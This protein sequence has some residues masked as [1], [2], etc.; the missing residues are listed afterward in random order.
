[1][2]ERSG[3]AILLGTALS[4]GA[5]LMLEVVL[6][7]IFAVAQFHHFAFVAV[8]LALLGF[9]AAGSFLYVWPRLG[10]GGPGR[11]ATLAALQTAAIIG[12]YMAANRVPFDSFTV[13]WDRR[14][15]LYLAI[16]YLALATPFFFAGALITALLAGWDQPRRVPTHRVYGAS[17]VGAG[18]GAPLA[19]VTIDRLGGEGA[20]VAAAALAALAVLFLLSAG[21][22]KR[23]AL[24][25]VGVLVAVTAGLLIAGPE[26]IELRL[27][28]YKELNAAL[29]YPGALLLSTEWTPASRVD[30]VESEGIR[31]LP[32]LS[33]TY[34]GIPPAQQ[35]V[36]VDGDDLSPI[37]LVEPEQADF[38]PYLLYALPYE[39][40]QAAETL[41]LDAGGGLA[42]ITALNSGAANVTA[43]EPDPMVA[44]AASTSPTYRDPAVEV[45]VEDI[46]T[47]V[48]RADRGFDV[49]HLALDSPFRPVTSGAYSLAEDYSLT[50]E[51]VSAYLDVL[52]PGGVLAV[53]R[54]LQTPPS[55]GIRAVALAGEAIR[56][57]G[58]DP[59]S[60]VVALR[61]F[62]N[63][64]VM[65]APDGFGADQL[66]RVRDFAERLRFDLVAFPGL[67]AS[68]ANRFNRLPEDDYFRL[69]S[70]LLV[71]SVPTDLYQSY[72]FDITPPTDNHP[73]FHHYFTFEQTDEVLATLGRTWQPFGGAGYF[74][75]VALL[76]L[77][78]LAAGLLILGPLAMRAW[79]E[80][81]LGW[82]VGYFGLLGLAFLL[83]EIP[84][85]QR[86]ILV[87][88]RPTTALAVVLASVLVASGLGSLMSDRL[89]W[90]GT[91]IVL[92]VV[93]VVQPWLVAGVIE[94]SLGTPFWLRAA[95][96]AGSVLPVGFLMGTMFPKGIDY[97]ETTSPQLIPWAWGINGAAS[98]VAAI[99]A[100][101]AALS[102]GFTA[103]MLVGA[104]CYGGATLLA[105][106]KTRVG[107][108]EGLAAG[109]TPLNLPG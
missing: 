90:L 8:S 101:L 52:R 72:T 33:F 86:Y 20:V 63:L 77:S 57:R 42:V 88:G 61:G 56:R 97:L 87:L 30:H 14:Q 73:F 89:P 1:M 69:A 36:T 12:G 65:V 104:A 29:R 32:G 9:G 108:S 22:S 75:L 102:W 44:E 80:P 40:R 94:L 38:V 47:F 109:P 3:S 62:S 60:T 35:G 64:L 46:R 37:P 34:R 98:V 13:A 59:A 71:E 21:S 91:A 16:V 45:V 53:V 27:S 107:A 26:S 7:R 55:E 76:M 4:S 54:W 82:T 15:I 79:R 24:P 93:A 92:S 74:L 17:L 31:S 6:T 19:L 81:G 99:A 96:V 67:D 50:L 5:V 105:M 68:E 83:V 10:R 95:L 49:V 28:P 48:E 103:V 43:V 11:W 18:I 78:I 23:Q 25:A 41:V 58:G 51:A 70:L 66:N 85:F 100:A 2:G 84:I 39:L 106:A